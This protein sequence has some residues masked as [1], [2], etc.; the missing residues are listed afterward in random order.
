MI[1]FMMRLP[2][3]RPDS[4]ESLL[5]RDEKKVLTSSV[6]VGQLSPLPARG[7]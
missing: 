1:F 2:G 3:M 7:G 6:A 4:R 5:F